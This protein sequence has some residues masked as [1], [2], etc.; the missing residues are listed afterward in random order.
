VQRLL[1][2]AAAVERMRP[3]IHD[4]LMARTDSRQ[5]LVR[6]LDALSRLLGL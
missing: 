5:R 2:V 4:E 1:E 3:L 6:E